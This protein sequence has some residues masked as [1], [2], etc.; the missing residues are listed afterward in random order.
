V[1]PT[2][3]TARGITARVSEEQFARF[4]NTC[5]RLGINAYQ[6]SAQ[7][8]SMWCDEIEAREAAAAA[9]F[10]ALLER[11]AVSA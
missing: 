4:R 1:K 5:D 9:N 10:A 2:E 3:A 8:I 7:A 6:A 11:A